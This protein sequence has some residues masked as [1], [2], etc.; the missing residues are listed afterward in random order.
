MR[1]LFGEPH[2]IKSIDPSKTEHKAFRIEEEGLKRL[3]DRLQQSPIAK[4]CANWI[5]QKV[6]IKSIRQSN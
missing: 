2:F 3:T 1:F 5:K 4:D 6:Q